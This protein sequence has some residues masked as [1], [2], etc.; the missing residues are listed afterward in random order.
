[1]SRG[2]HVEQ[3]L[4]VMLKPLRMQSVAWSECAAGVI[5]SAQ[6]CLSAAWQCISLFAYSVH[7]VQW[8]AGLELGRF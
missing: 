2:T 8:L 4:Y 6:P 7:V 5:M 3:L 1:M